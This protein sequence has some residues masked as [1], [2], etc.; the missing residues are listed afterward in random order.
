MSDRQHPN[1]A[2]DAEQETSD[3]GEG[4]RGVIAPNHGGT[5]RP[6]PGETGDKAEGESGGPG[7]VIPHLQDE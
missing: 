1:N 3:F 5:F 7:V 2:E 4:E 6:T